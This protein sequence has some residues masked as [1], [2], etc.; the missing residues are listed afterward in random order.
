M[1]PFDSNHDYVNDYVERWNGGV[2][3][4]KRTMV[5]LGILLALSGILVVLSPLSTYSLIQSIAAVLLIVHGAGQIGSWARTPEPFRSGATLAAGVLN[6]LLGL[7][8]ILL[9]PSFMAS[10]L[11]YLIAFM[12]IVTGVERISFSRQMRFFSIPTSSAG[13]ATGVLNIILGAV[14]IF[15]PL[16]SSIVLSY[17]IA[18]YLVIGGI[19][20]LVEGIAIKGIER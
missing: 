10:T 5:V 17:L 13:T 2:R 15:L 4:T 7:L 14:F 3:A 12:L 19:T 16:V 8:F 6:A 1:S 18:A 9:P 20:L 11:V